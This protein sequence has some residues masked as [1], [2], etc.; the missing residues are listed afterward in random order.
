MI[1]L[2]NF[3]ASNNSLYNLTNVYD[4]VQYN[5]HSSLTEVNADS[6]NWSAIKIAIERVEGLP[7]EESEIETAIR[8]CQGYWIAQHFCLFPTNQNRF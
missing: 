6:T 8:T 7:L 5:F 3:S 2:P 1:P 4:Y